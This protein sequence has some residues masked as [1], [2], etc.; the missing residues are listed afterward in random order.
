[1]RR[2]GGRVQL[3]VRRVLGAQELARLPALCAQDLL[4]KGCGIAAPSGVVGVVVE[5]AAAVF[6]EVDEA[7][8]G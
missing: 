2:V 5:F 1:M 8:S 4:A 6:F 7:R 3:R